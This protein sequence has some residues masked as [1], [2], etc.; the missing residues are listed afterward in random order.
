MVT[1]KKGSLFE[2]LISDEKDVILTHACNCKGVWGSGIAPVFKQRWPEVYAEYESRCREY[3][4]QLLG[5]WSL[6]TAKDGTKI[7]CLYTSRGYGDQVD[8][9][10]IIVDAT[11]EALKSFLNPKENWDA[12]IHMP[13]INSGRFRV[14]WEKTAYILE[15]FSQIAEVEEDKLKFTVWEL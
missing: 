13:K 8:S 14:P 4:D 2:A 12:N 5:T 10:D 11:R 6:H 3:G 1:Y 7:L 9:P 15:I